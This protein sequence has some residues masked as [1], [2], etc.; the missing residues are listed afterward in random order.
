MLTTGWVQKE[1]KGTHTFG[2]G[3]FKKELQLSGLSKEHQRK[4]ERE[5][6]E[7]QKRLADMDPLV[8]QLRQYR[9]DAEHM[10]KSSQMAAIDAKLKSGEGL[11]PEEEEYLKQTNPDGYREY[12]EIRQER[13]TYKE[14]LKHCKTKE[15]VE[16]LKLNKMGNFLAEAKKV[17]SNPVIPKGAKRGLLEK[18]LKKAAGIQKSHTAFTKTAKYHGLPTEEELT[19][20]VKEKY[21]K[22]PS[23]ENMEAAGLPS[24]EGI[25]GVPEGAEDAESPSGEGITGMPEGAEGA[26][27]PSGE[28]MA[29]VPKGNQGKE[30]QGRPAEFEDVEQEIVGFLTTD[31]PKGYGLEYLG[32]NT[33]PSRRV[34][35]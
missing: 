28:D 35:P 18:I 6:K 14:Q 23:A 4:A 26:E 30:S 3:R 34:Y 25:T 10:R 20:K 31:R 5:E 24:E 21:K 33:H 19:E 2:A 15:E 17:S 12:Q 29:G 7:Q 13:E 11:T 1:E 16:K 32:P 9:E 22:Q 27:S 8:R